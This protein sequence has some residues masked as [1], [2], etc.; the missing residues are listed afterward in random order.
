M[1]LTDQ[2]A[3][4]RSGEALDAKKIETFLRD[5]IAGLTGDIK[6]QQF[7]RG[8]SNLTYLVS[9]GT[10]EFVL[11]RPPFGTKAATAHDMG[12]E[13]RVLSA[14]SGVYP[15]SPKPIAFCGDTE[16]IGA[17]FYVMEPIRGII[18]R[19]EFPETLKL[20]A[21]EVTQLFRRLVEAQFALHTIDYHRIGLADFGKPE[22]YVER[23]VLGWSKRY[24]AARTPDAPE[25][26]DIMQWLAAH[27]P[28]ESPQPGVIHNDFKLDNVVLDPRDPLKIIGVLDWEMATVGDPLMDLGSSL[29]YWVQ[30]DDPPELQAIRFVP[31]HA[32]GALTREQVVAYYAELSGNPVDNFGFYLVFGIF[33]L[34]VI[35]QQIYYRFYHGQTRDQRFGAFIIGV[36]VLD[37]AARRHIERCGG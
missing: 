18:I 31:T 14:L 9:V 32:A 29:G 3:Q 1:T 2:A 24:R 22:G 13:Y 17:P 10:R 15:Y 23:Q 30:A 33:R 21:G 35:A 34:A 27:M 26:E 19:R 12:R 20:P 36:N 28:P 6:V 8:H 16:L 7:P 25:S 37:R 11:R 5:T 4:V